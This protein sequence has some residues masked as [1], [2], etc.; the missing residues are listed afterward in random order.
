MSRKLIMAPGDGGKKE[1]GE[2]R[3]YTG[4]IKKKGEREIV[5]QRPVR[6]GSGVKI[7]LG[8]VA[9]NPIIT[10]RSPGARSKKRG[11][12]GDDNYTR[13]GKE[14]T[15][16]VEHKKSTARDPGAS[17]Q[18]QFKKVVMGRGGKGGAG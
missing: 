3:L 13:A 15:L 16:N 7:L 10:L 11:G 6:R 14:L 2:R 18:V 9:S 8:A 4:K 1:M 12:K 5:T 17:E